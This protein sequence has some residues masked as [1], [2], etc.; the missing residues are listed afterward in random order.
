M[1][2]NVRTLIALGMMLA[3]TACAVGTGGRKSV[4]HR[5]WP[6]VP[7]GAQLKSAMKSI[8]LASRQRRSMRTQL[9]IA[10]PFLPGGTA[11]DGVLA[12]QPDS[13]LR[14]DLLDPT[15]GTLAALNL[16]DDHLEMWLPQQNRMYQTSA[17]DD[18]LQRLT[19]LPWTLSELF[20]LLQGLPPRRFAEEYIDWSIDPDGMAVNADG[21]AIMSFGPGM[22]PE[23]YIR[24]RNDLQ[25]KIVY[26]VTF[27]EY[28][29]SSL[30]SYPTHITIQFYA[31]KT[32][33]EIWLSDVEWNPPLAWGEWTLEP[34]AGT[35]VIELR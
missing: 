13:R 9:K 19:R 24:Y 12:A 34:P 33:V 32:V 4:H 6:V 11:A 35:K 29:T 25:K 21:D 20:S 10:A 5:D 15:G 28:Q 2:W 30:G 1:L 23:F 31:P 7:S 17:S 27:E 26:E 3:L 22:L 16:N 18:S 14:L 8:D